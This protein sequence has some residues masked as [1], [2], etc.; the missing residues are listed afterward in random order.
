MVARMSN[1]NGNVTMNEMGPNNNTGII[2]MD[3]IIIVTTIIGI[4]NLINLY[5]PNIVNFTTNT[6]SDKNE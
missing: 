1:V 3:S 2:S 5:N 6:M 4:E